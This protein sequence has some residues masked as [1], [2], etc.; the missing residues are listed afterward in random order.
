MPAADGYFIVIGRPG[1]RIT[2][3]DSGAVTAAGTSSQRD[4]RSYCY[5]IT[6]GIAS[7]D[8]ASV[9]TAA[10]IQRVNLIHSHCPSACF[11]Q[12]NFVTVGIALACH[13]TAENLFQIDGATAFK[14]F[15]SKSVACSVADTISAGITGSNAPS[16]AHTSAVHDISAGIY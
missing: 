13:Y 12:Y 4:V 2:A 10:A 6:I 15:D 11:T 7:P 14:A 8:A 5:L 16:T 1:I 3:V 9:L